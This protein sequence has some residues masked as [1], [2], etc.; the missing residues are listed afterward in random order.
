L[1]GAFG[2]ALGLAL[3][4]GGGGNRAFG[5]AG[6]HG[7]IVQ[8]GA[9]RDL[10]QDFLFRFSSAFQ[11]VIQTRAMIHTLRFTHNPF[12]WSVPATSSGNDAACTREGGWRLGDL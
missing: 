1:S 8:A 7:G 5:Q 10:C 6:L 3:L 9:G 12:L 11:A 2:L 4:A